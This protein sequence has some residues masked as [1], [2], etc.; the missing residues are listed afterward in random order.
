MIVVRFLFLFELTFA[1]KRDHVIL[2]RQIKVFPIHARKFSLQ[3]NLLFVL[4][5][6]HAGTP[7]ASRNTFFVKSA[8]D[9]ASEK[10]VHFFLKSSQVA[11]R[12]I[13]NNT[14]NSQCLQ[15]PFG[16]FSRLDRVPERI[17][18]INAESGV[19]KS[20]IGGSWPSKN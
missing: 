12:V 10:P 9:T 17:A 19:V 8:R 3:H 15:S 4:I 16:L 20:R 18:I 11:K 14:H 2:D 6:I 1:A 5:D 7:R 13:S